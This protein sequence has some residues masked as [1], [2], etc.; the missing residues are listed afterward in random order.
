MNDIKDIIEEVKSRCDIVSTI[1]Q[2]IELKSSGINYKGLCPFHG[3]K[4]PSFYVNESKQIY[5]C[6]GCGEGGDVINFVMK[7]ENLDFIDAVKVLAQKYG[8]EINTNMDEESKK[9]LEK[10]KKFQDIHTEAARFYFSN[11]HTKK[12]SGYAYLRSRGLD[13]KIIKKFGLG[14][15]LAS[16]NSLMEYLTSK[17]YSNKDLIECGLLAHKK[18][19]NKIYDKFRNRVMFPIFDYR[20]NVIGFG[21]RVLDDSLPKYLNSPDTITFNKRYNLYG[22]N[23]SR[24]EIKNKT[25]ILVEGYMDLISLYQYG[26]K[27]VVAT[28]GTALTKE[29]GM[30]IKRY[31]DNVIISYDSDEAGIKATLRAIEIL[32]DIDIN[33]KVLNLKDCKDPDEFI[34]KYGVKGYQEAIDESINQIIFRINNLRKQ[35]N[36]NKDEDKVKFAKEASKIIKKVKSPVE[37]DYYTKYLSNLIQISTDSIKREIYGKNYNKTENNKYKK[38]KYIKKD[39]V[40]IEKPKIITNGEK[41][42]EKNLIKLMIEDKKLRDIIVL[43]VNDSDFL[44]DESK[45]IL[46]WIIK[47]QE[48]DK[49]TIDKIKSLNISEEY[50][51]DIEN[52]SLSNM[53]LTNV[54]GVDD[55]I[56]NVK[57]NTLNEKM[58]RLLKEQKEIEQN[59]NNSD[60]KEV[61]GKI[62]EIALKIVE[63]RR[64]LQKL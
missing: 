54:K 11:L 20:G 30:L 53:S 62:M 41:F 18:E 57:K 15:S 59:K 58:N 44:L 39:E 42:V 8:I 24:K 37:I 61:D 32:S 13:D 28:L 45:E 64:M 33:V 46:N 47:N 48:L 5:K 55:I 22:L 26:I 43:K 19:S 51:K 50:I 9:K 52:I 23:F 17:G 49:I 4:T 16:W 63:I 36:L 14:Y 56:K 38:S 35:F 12:N 2:Y 40:V 6:F 21:G 7:M 31:A 60:T 34:R 27:N 29:Q 10:I 3:E 1:S 25:L